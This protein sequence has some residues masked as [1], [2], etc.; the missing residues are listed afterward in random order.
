M[1]TLQSTLVAV[2]LTFVAGLHAHAQ[3]PATPDAAATT[4][5]APTAS[6]GPDGLIVRSADGSFQF[7]L[8]GYFQSDIRAAADDPDDAVLDTFVLR[9]V[10]PI[11]EATV[12]ERFSFR[13]MPDFG[14]GRVTLFDAHM[15]VRLSPALSVRAGKFKSPFG[16]E[17]LQS[18]TDLLFV[19]RA[20]PT[21]V[22]PNRDV[23]IMASGGWAQRAQWAVA[24]AN[25]T[26]DGEQRSR[27][28]FGQGH[29]GAARA[30][31]ALRARRRPVRNADG[32]TGSR[33]RDAPWQRAA[34]RTFAAEDAGAAS[35]LPVSRRRG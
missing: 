1:G 5:P 17:R 13:L 25:G 23:G 30:V 35:H 8:R 21:A 28:G 6:A 14:E 33:S 31:P 9:R 22:V 20:F 27:R 7:R 16:L 3:T 19:E 18:A 12:C 29:R 24:L 4:P 15:D 10:R 2:A 34:A 32:R 11:L 26:A